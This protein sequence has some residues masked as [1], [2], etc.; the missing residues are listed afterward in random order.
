MAA[1]GDGE[2]N[3]RKCAAQLFRTACRTAYL[4]ASV[5]QQQQVEQASDGAA[6]QVLIVVGDRHVCQQPQSG[7]LHRR[8]QGVSKDVLTDLRDVYLKVR[9]NH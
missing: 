5:S 2:F 8:V 3:L 1:H 4:G 9:E 7:Q 6:E